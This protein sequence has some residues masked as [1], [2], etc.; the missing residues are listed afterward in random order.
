MSNLILLWTTTPHLRVVTST[1]CGMAQACICPCLYSMVAQLLC[2]PQNIF[3]VRDGLRKVPSVVV[4]WSEVAVCPSLL[5]LQHHNHFTFTKPQ[6]QVE[7]SA[8]LN[9][10]PHKYSQRT[11]QCNTFIPV[12]MFDCWPVLWP[13]CLIMP[14][15]SIN[16]P[17]WNT[18]FFSQDTL[19]SYHFLLCSHSLGCPIHILT[20]PHCELHVLFQVAQLTHLAA[21]LYG[22]LSVNN[23]SYSSCLYGYRSPGYVNPLT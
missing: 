8:S 20:V 15:L 1:A 9:V 14:K 12:S 22:L 10:Q 7:H 13:G 19:Q 18:I 5:H 17:L 6:A 3:M 4:W 16:A 2:N 11:W 23:C 21:D